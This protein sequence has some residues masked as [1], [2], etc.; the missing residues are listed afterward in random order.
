MSGQGFGAAVGSAVGSAVGGHL[1]PPQSVVTP[2]ILSKG[3]DHAGAE[4]PLVS[5]VQR[6]D[7]RR[8]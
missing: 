5:R 6:V 1:S 2:V 3:V 8:R 7:I 4:L